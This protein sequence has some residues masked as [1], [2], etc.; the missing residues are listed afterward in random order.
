MD[1]ATSTRSACSS[2]ARAP[3]ILHKRPERRAH[4][5]GG[6]ARR[7]GPGRRRRSDPAR[8]RGAQRSLPG[9]AATRT[10]WKP[11][12]ASPRAC[13]FDPRARARRAGA[14]ST[15]TA[16]S[17]SR[18]G[19]STRSTRPADAQEVVASLDSRMRLSRSHRHATAD[20]LG[21]LDD[22][23]AQRSRGSARRHPRA[24]RA[25]RAALPRRLTPMARSRSR[26]HRP[27]RRSLCND[28]VHDRPGGHDERR[29]EAEEAGQESSPEVTEGE[30]AGQA[31]RG[32]EG[33]RLELGPRPRR[34]RSARRRRRRI[35]RQRC[36][37]AASKSRG[38]PIRGRT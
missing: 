3:S 24:P 6:R 32:E 27:S 14:P 38:V 22:E 30:A 19:R 2:S 29:L 31:R 26:R 15:S 20:R 36:S 18:K 33:F 9:S 1:A 37:P 11:A 13:D 7:G 17:S 12:S 8:L 4:R 16:A 21:L 23:E 10:C 28:G 25:R 34:E 35:S 5:A